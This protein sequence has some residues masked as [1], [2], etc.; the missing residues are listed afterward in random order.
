MPP[1]DRDRH[2]LPIP[3]PVRLIAWLHGLL[4]DEDLSSSSSW[5]DGDGYDDED[6]DDEAVPGPS[7]ESPHL[8]DLFVEVEYSSTHAG[9]GIPYS[10]TLPTYPSDTEMDGDEGASGANERPCDCEFCRA[11][12]EE[13]EAAVM[14]CPVEEEQ[15]L[16]VEEVSACGSSEPGTPSSSI[17]FSAVEDMDVSGSWSP[18]SSDSFVTAWSSPPPSPSPSSTGSTISTSSIPSTVVCTVG[19]ERLSIGDLSSD[20]SSSE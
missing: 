1:E 16:E 10:P 4:A 13:E 8:M 9:P 7:G 19:S 17:Y 12:K 2:R 6:D 15:E 11:V 20:G 3:P 5:S 14:E 18:S